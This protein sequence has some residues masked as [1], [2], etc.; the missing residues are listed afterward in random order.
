LAWTLEFSDKAISALATLDKQTSLRII[1]YLE[2]RAAPL[3][4]PRD[5]G[6]A[7][8]GSKY[9]GM[10]RYRVGDCRV[11]AEILDQRVSI[12]VIEIGHRREIYR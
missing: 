2:T 12:L 9:G 5:L 10:W 11:I 4:N 8:K 1:A 7:L 3:A 6:H